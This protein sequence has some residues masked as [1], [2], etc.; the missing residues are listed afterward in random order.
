M[1]E[2]PEIEVLRHEIEESASGREITGIDVFMKRFE[3]SGAE[4]AKK[5]VGKKISGAERYGKYLFLKAG[6]EGAVAMH[7]G[8]T[9]SLVPVKGYAKPPAFTRFIIRLD[10]GG[11]AYVSPRP[12]GMIRYVKTPGDFVREKHLGPDA[13][14]ISEKDFQALFEGDQGAVKALFMD[15]EKIAG[16][17]NVYSD[18]ML[19]QCGIHP[20]TPAEKVTPRQAKALYKSMKKVLKATMDVKGDRSKLPES[21]LVRHRRGKEACPRCGGRVEQLD[22]SGRR[23]YY[24]PACQKLPS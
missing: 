20:K 18:E 2:L 12:F 9:G 23:A 6:A 21:Y 24:C 4:A 5:A 13:A 11:L 19:F 1:P 14:A 10:R 17:G 16:L 3:K 22:F 8:L 15:Q 7:F